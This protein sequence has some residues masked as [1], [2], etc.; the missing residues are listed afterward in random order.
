MLHLF[1]PFLQH[2]ELVREGIK[3]QRHAQNTERCSNQGRRFIKTW[4]TFS[5]T[6]EQN[7]WNLTQPDLIYLFIHWVQKEYS[8]HRW[9]GIREVKYCGPNNMIHIDMLEDVCSHHVFVVLK[10]VVTRPS[11]Q[12]PN[13][14]THE[15]VKTPLH[16][17]LIK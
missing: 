12:N 10:T 11:H 3:S 17:W 5:S 9:T 8:V 15:S 6:E 1:L 4:M 16:F 7:A 2:F 14:A 13:E